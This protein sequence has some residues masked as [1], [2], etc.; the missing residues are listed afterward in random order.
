MV[1]WSFERRR[2]E[3]EVSTVINRPVST[4]WE[5]Y[6]VNHVENH[7][8]WDPSLELAAK[9]DGPIGVGTVIERRATRFGKT[10]E[11]TM[12]VVEFE[13]EKAMRV[14]TQDG[15][16]TI[17]G[18]VLFDAVSE[19]ETRISLGGEFPGMDDSMEEN[20]RPMMERS[21]ATIKDLIESEH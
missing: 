18:W 11:G 21:A 15:P 2:M 10:T 13:P 7:P 12:E 14:R 1:R 5:F 9:S 4:V 19:G 16:M 8:R 20:I 6:A 17:N 3:L